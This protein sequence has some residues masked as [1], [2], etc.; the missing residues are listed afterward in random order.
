MNLKEI[1]TPSELITANETKSNL[2]LAIAAS[3][4]L[5]VSDTKE[6]LLHLLDLLGTAHDAVAEAEM[7][8]GDTES[9]F[10]WSKDEASIHIA[11]NIINSIEL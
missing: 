9:A 5:A 6:L 2:E 8:N 11:W 1:T 4:H 10:A 7:K 3:D